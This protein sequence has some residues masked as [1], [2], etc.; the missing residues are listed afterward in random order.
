MKIRKGDK[1]K[2]IIGKDKGKDGVVTKVLRP[3]NKIVVEGVNVYKKHV[4][5][6][7]KFKEG[8]IV[9][10]EKPLNVSNVMLICPKCSAATRVGFK[11]EGGKK[12]RVC[13]KCKEVIGGNK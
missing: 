6:S 2:V 10:V 12:Y 3:K 13:K 8:G 5:P 9:E 11:I 4:K 1:V 7:A